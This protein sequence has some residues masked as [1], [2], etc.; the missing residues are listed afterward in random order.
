MW[1]SAWE[2]FPPRTQPVLS[3]QVP[4]ARWQETPGPGSTGC[5]WPVLVR[6]CAHF[7]GDV[8]NGSKAIGLVRLLDQSSGPGPIMARG[9]QTLADSS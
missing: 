2:G 1:L 5:H 6:A 4:L 9:G 3:I 7:I 8:G